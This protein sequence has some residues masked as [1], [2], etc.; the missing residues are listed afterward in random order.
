MK[1]IKNSF[2]GIVA[3]AIAVFSFAPVGVARAD[4]IVTVSGGSLSVTTQQISFGSVSLTGADQ[5]A[6][7]TTTA[8]VVTDPT[9][10]GAG[11]R[12]TIAATSFTSSSNT[13]PVSGFR[14][15]LA[16]ASV[17]TVGGN[18]KP[19]SNMTTAAV[20][21]TTAQ[22]LLTAAANTGLGTYNATPTFT[23]L[24]P[25]DTKAGSY[26]STVTVTIVSGP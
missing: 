2:I 1:K 16:D 14:A 3:A 10:T 18:T 13:I 23:L 17:T 11:Y 21:S 19:T 7:G 20:L 4:A 9:G 12:V 8:W 25:A 6:N 22:T 15:T 24:V 26:T 5:T